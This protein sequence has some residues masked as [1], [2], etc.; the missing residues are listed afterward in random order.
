MDHTEYLTDRP[1]VTEVRHMISKYYTYE[2]PTILLTV[3][4]KKI[5]SVVQLAVISTHSHPEVLVDGDESYSLF[6]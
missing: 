6:A 5:A 3:C 2:S 1:F 4:C